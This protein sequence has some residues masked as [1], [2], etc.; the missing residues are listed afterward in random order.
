MARTGE[1]TPDRSPLYAGITAGPPSGHG[2]EGGTGWV[3]GAS[4]GYPP[5]M[6]IPSVLPSG[7]PKLTVRSRPVR[8]SRPAPRA[9]PPAAPAVCPPARAGARPAGG[10]PLL[11]RAGLPAPAG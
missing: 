8:S 11:P 5:D 6:D 2:P 4:Q 1:S 7:N 3:P 9:G 10:G